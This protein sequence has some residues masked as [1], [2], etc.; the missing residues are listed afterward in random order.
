MAGSCAACC[1]SSIGNV[2]A[3]SCF[4]CLQGRGAGG[5]WPYLFYSLIVG[6]PIGLALGGYIAETYVHCFSGNLICRVT[7]S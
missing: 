5:V 2:P 6:V 7:D 3:G 1:Q 4:A